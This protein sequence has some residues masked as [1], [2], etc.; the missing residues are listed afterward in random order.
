[1]DEMKVNIKGIK[2][3]NCAILW[4]TK[5]EGEEKERH[6]QKNDKKHNAW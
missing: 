2:S 4:E 5:V 3:N 6:K 1:M